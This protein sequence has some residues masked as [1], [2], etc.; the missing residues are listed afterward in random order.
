MSRRYKKKEKTRQEV[1]KAAGVLFEQKGFAATS[2]DDVAELANIAKGT[3]YYH[4][5]SKDD[6]LIGLAL[7]YHKEISADVV[8]RLENKEPPIDILRMVTRDIAV[9]TANNQE[10]ARMFYTVAFSLFGELCGEDFE[11]NPYTLPNIF[12]K[13]IEVAQ[14]LGQISSSVKADELS[15]MLTGVFHQAQ[16]TWLVLGEKRSLPEKVDSW[17]TLWLEGVGVTGS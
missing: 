16:V 7:E 17:I 13:I 8:Q 9:N 3:F 15:I 11:S 1:L 12:Q 10:T 6:L 4:F 2:V 14:D 5:K